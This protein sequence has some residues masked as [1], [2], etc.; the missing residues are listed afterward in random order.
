MYSEHLLP[1]TGYNA[2]IQIIVINNATF[3]FWTNAQRLLIMY[4]IVWIGLYF[5]LHFN[6]I[7]QICLLYAFV[8]F[9]AENMD[10]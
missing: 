10:S 2:V 8:L 7:G 1:P 5:N 9:C 3:F 6:T 4:C